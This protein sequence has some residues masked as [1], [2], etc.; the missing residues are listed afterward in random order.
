MS[1]HQN[2]KYLLVGGGLASSAA[3]VA[4][5]RIDRDGTILLIGQESTRPYYRRPL[6]AEFL[7][8]TVTRESLFIQPAE[9]YRENH[10]ELHTAVR[11]AHLDASRK[12]MAL[13][14]G[15]VVAFDKLLIATGAAPKLLTIPGAAMANVHY[16]RTVADA[17]RLHNA[18]EKA[19][20]EGHL[21]EHQGQRRRGA[22]TI[23]GNGILA[24]ELAQ[25]LKGLDLT[26]DLIVAAPHPWSRFAGESAGKAIARTLEKHGVHLHL[27]AEAIAVEGSG[28]A[29]RIALSNGQTVPCD[30]M[31]A[32]VGHVPA[33]DL[34]RGTPIEGE[35]AILTDGHCRTNLPD[36][37]AAGDC[38]AMFD[39]LFAKH[40]QLD[41]WDSAS[42]T[43]TLAGQN[44][45]GV[46]VAF[47]AISHLSSHIFGVTMNVWGD[48]RHIAYRIVRTARAADGIDMIEI[49]VAADGRIAQV[50]ALNHPQE[51]AE[52]Q[53]LVRR[54]FQ[55]KGH[56][57]ALRDTT[58]PFS[59]ILET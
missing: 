6:S 30:F 42:A 16:L 55:V 10:I 12:S 44:M 48:A 4:I 54:R 15:D 49:G 51:T 9:W 25:T 19:K 11:A 27:Q 33:K 14:N 37:Y 35:R 23:I 32:A 13:D 36:I 52:L 20:R 43:G 46:D 7:S 38:A 1:H 41:R 47:S 3:A 57:D 39:P 29:Q 58:Q 56:E 31:V 34:L 26:V 2:V 50:L 5:R 21:V 8:A 17:D 40:R 53:E 24:L 18:I 22:A 59:S 45:A 28:R